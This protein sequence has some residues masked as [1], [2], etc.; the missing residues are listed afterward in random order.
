MNLVGSV[1]FTTRLQEK[2]QSHLEHILVSQ[3]YYNRTCL[4]FLA[5]LLNII[6]HVLVLASVHLHGTL[7]FHLVMEWIKD[8]NFHNTIHVISVIILKCLNFAL[9]SFIRTLWH[10]T[11]NYSTLTLNFKYP[12]SGIRPDLC[13][14]CFIPSRSFVIPIGYHSWYCDIL[15]QNVKVI[16]TYMTLYYLL[17]SFKAVLGSLTLLRQGVT[18]WLLIP[19]SPS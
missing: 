16:P 8:E 4:H 1:V 17:F 10:T 13:Y 2:F 9:Y 3:Y 12:V 7:L 11:L 15:T 5:A 14:Y 18:T 19:S 6:F